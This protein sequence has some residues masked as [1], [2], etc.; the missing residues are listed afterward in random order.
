MRREEPFFYC[1][2]VIYRTFLLSCENFKNLV[3][4]KGVL[5][6]K[7]YLWDHSANIDFFINVKVKIQM[8][9][10]YV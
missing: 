8:I 4:Q 5:D 2:F 7:G 3:K 9:E 10:Y 6:G 1:F